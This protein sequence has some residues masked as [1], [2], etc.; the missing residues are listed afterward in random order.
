MRLLSLVIVVATG[1]G[2]L[3]FD[4]APDTTTDATTEVLGTTDGMVLQ[5]S[6]ALAA[7]SPSTTDGL[8][9]IQA[10]SPTDIW[11]AGLNGYIGH[12]DGT[13]WSTSPSGRTDGLYVFWA[14][15]PNDLWL[16]GGGCTL[17]RW[18]GASW[19]PMPVQGCTGQKAFYSIDGS[20]TSNV[21]VVGINGNLFQYNG[22]S[23]VDRNQG[24]YVFW[25]VAVRSPS[26][27]IL[28]GQQGL[29]LRWGGTQFTTDTAPDVTLT[30]IAKVSATES[31]IVGSNGTTLQST[32][33][34]TWTSVPSPVTSGTL[35]GVYAAAANDIWA[36]GVGGVIIRYDGTTWTQVQSPTTTTL[37][38]IAGIPGGG[39]IAVGD[40]GVVLIH[41]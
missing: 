15:S 32:T 31:W 33:P 27:V 18:Q 24:N 37:R 30:A 19:T 17:L 7:N 38:N 21:W 40:G 26:D 41:P 34:G 3:G 8:W 23:W 1:C 9:G 6:W 13:A 2:R 35:Y 28:S 29:I 11:I 25:S 22:A 10:F 4:E 12:Y 16:A 20:S 36:V 39:M 5:S 14:A